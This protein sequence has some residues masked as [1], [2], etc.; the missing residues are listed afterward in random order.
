M[1]ST[2]THSSQVIDYQFYKL[3]FELI[4]VWNSRGGICSYGKQLNS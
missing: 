4:I 3:A 2:Y 1:W